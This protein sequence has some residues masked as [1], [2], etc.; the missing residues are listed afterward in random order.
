MS[1]LVDEYWPDP[2]LSLL[3]MLQKGVDCCMNLVGRTDNPVGRGDLQASTERFS[4]QC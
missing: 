2:L 4:D 1:L 3:C